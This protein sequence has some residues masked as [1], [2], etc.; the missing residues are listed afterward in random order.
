MFDEISKLKTATSQDAVTLIEHSPYCFG[1]ILDYLRLKRFSSI[2]LGKEPA[3]PIVCE[4]KKEMFEKV[5]KYY[6]PGESSDP[7]LG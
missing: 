3:P 4:H 7:I 1:K 5:V 2:G 6:F